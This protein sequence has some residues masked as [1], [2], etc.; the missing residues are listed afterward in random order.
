MSVEA[1][2][3]EAIKMADKTYDMLELVEKGFMEHKAEY[4]SAAIVL[5]RELND[6]ERTLTQKVFD[7]AKIA[8]TDKEKKDLII[9]EQ[10]IETLERMGDEA[11]NLVERIEIKNA[12]HL[13]FSDMGVVQFN[14]TYAIMKKSVDMM[15]L[16]LKGKSEELRDRIIDNGF[17]VRALVQR[18]REEHTARLVNG[19]C[20]PIAA[21][22]YFDM[23][24]FTGNLARHASAVVKFF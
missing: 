10:V 9:W 11:A 17:H 5:E 13:L 4:L 16:F 8:K 18:Y 22:M 7:M 20:T 2:H 23:L 3:D 19:V 14:E 21:N 1:V 15:R 6:M 12:E 24:D